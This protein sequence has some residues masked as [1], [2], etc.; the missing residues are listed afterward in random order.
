MLGQ[1]VKSA[2]PLSQTDSKEKFRDWTA[3][4]QLASFS[5][6]YT[7][8]LSV[9]AKGI[10]VKAKNKKVILFPFRYD[11]KKLSKCPP[12]QSST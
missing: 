11:K 4:L 8:P 5:K 9:N 3:S 1:L 10:C 12:P 7:M 6:L 2:T